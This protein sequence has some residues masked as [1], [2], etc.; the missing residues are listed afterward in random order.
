MTFI[1]K[2]R[3]LT[4]KEEITDGI[5]RQAI[6]TGMEIAREEIKSDSELFIGSMS[7]LAVCLRTIIETF[8][9]HNESKI[10]DEIL[11]NLIMF[12]ED[13]RSQRR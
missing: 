1:D 10:V 8:E 12:F 11:E 7:A 4:E 6:L 2:L 5:V 3:K 13:I 9:N